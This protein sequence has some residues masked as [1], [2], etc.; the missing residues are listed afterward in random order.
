MRSPRRA[1]DTHLCRRHE[2]RARR[3]WPRLSQ[4]CV[5][6]ASSDSC[7]TTQ[8]PDPSLQFQRR[9][10][11][12]FPFVSGSPGAHGSKGCAIR[13][14]P[15]RPDRPASGRPLTQAEGAAHARALSPGRCSRGAARPRGIAPQARRRFRS[16]TPAPRHSPAERWKRAPRAAPAPPAGSPRR[17]TGPAP[18]RASRPGRG[19][20]HVSRAGAQGAEPRPRW[21]AQS[22]G[23]QALC[24]APQ[25]GLRERVQ[26]RPPQ[27]AGPGP[28]PPRVHRF[29]RPLR[30]GV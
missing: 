30:G 8:A 9:S 17:V 29:S 11:P 5:S 18:P 28:P 23:L 3:S 27:S 25:A 20:D 7:R 26:S 6:R 14:P 22:L 1:A 12:S 19:R 2:G 16:G 10:S 4:V 21:S 15:T 13:A 24:S